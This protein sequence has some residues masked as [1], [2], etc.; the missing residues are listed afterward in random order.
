MADSPQTRSVKISSDE[1][2]GWSSDRPRRDGAPPRP[3]DV[4]VRCRVLS[5]SDSLRYSPGSLLV[6]VSGSGQA[7]DDLTDRVLESR[8][9]LLSIGKVRGLLA[10]RVPEEEMESRAAEL[11][12]AAALKRL[13]ASETVVLAANGL[14]AEER[15]R[16]VRA[17]AKL[18]RPRHLI[19]LETARDQV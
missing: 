11:L 14:D 18:K 10:G 16:F 17:A 15:E 2:G 5:P 19:L 6:I 12:E 9:A 4:S 1:R 13:E 7:L 3:A 8:G